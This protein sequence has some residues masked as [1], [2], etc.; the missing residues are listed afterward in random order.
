MLRFPAFLGIAAALVL[1]QNTRYNLDESKVPPYTMPDPL[2][3]A[4]GTK[5]TNAG[6]WIERRRP[7]LVA[8]F[9]QQVYGRTPSEEIP[10]RTGKV[11]IDPKALGGKAI[12]KQVTLYFTQRIDGPQ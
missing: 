6:S 10:R 12:R 5:V 8:L 4:D 1:A 7:E 2:T 11:L 3:L 9:E